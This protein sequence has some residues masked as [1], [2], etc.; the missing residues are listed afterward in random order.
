MMCCIS[1]PSTMIAATATPNEDHDW[2]HDEDQFPKSRQH[3]SVS[4]LSLPRS[5]KPRR[6]RPHPRS[7]GVSFIATTDSRT[8]VPGLASVRVHP[9]QW[10]L[11]RT[12]RIEAQ[13]R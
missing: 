12:S 13:E 7:E 11:K 8:P 5:T 6:G 2:E 10:S 4:P 9:V 3:V 1:H